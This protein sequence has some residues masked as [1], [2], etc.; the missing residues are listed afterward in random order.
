MD[1]KPVTAV[2]SGPAAAGG[3]G[4]DSSSSSSSS[5]SDSD[6]DED[7]GC[8]GGGGGNCGVPLIMFAL[9]HHR[10]AFTAADGL[11]D[12]GTSTLY[13]QVRTEELGK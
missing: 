6:S 12:L 1:G 11:T 8:G 9:L 13:G 7:S 2:S 5:D 4:N 3:D 10:Q